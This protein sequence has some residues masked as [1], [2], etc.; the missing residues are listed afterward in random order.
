MAEFINETETS[1]QL[2]VPSFI[3]EAHVSYIKKIA[4]DKES[5]EFIVTE[6]LRMSGVYWALT[7]MSL[8][9][10]NIFQELDADEIV[11]WVL[12]C[13]DETTGGFGGSTGHDPHML[14]TLSA[15][16]IL[17]ICRKLDLINAEKV[18]LYI[19][20]LQQSDG[21]FFGDIWGEIDTR[22]SYCAVSTL[23]ILGKLHENFINL[24]KAMEYVARCKNFDGGFGAVPGA[25][26]HAGQIFC[27]VA[28]LS[29]GGALHL[30]ERDLLTWW[31]SERQCDSGGLNGRPEKQAD[32]CYSWWILS[33]LSILG[34]VSWIDRDHL[35]CFILQCQDTDEDG[36][37]ISDRPGNMTDI[38]H[39]FFGIAGLSLLG[40][41][42]LDKHKG[43][44][45]M[46]LDVDPT[47]ALPKSLTTELGL[48]CQVL[49]SI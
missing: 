30:V 29:I 26:S 35:A 28:A 14:Y 10:K 44:Y 36:G 24:E 23:S 16:Q 18:A 2:D 12:K 34:R 7:A 1:V 4:N 40:Y 6:H 19:S 45:E 42:H 47:Y 5:F 46:F 8:L 32:V 17:A 21:S 33:S 37:G 41:F 31:L 22:F 25:E 27:C 20:S 13:Q 39:T 3:E 49:E 15:I 38:F 43:K 9:G 48:T 11:Q